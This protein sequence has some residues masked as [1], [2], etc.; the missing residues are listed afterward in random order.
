VIAIYEKYKIYIIGGVICFALGFGVQFLS[1]QGQLQSLRVRADQVNANYNR[2]RN[3]LE[4]SQK[5][6]ADL[7]K[8]IGAAGETV[9]G[10]TNTASNIEKSNREIRESVNMAIREIES[11]GDGFKDARRILETVQNRGGGED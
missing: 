9:A 6:L 4:S 3:E 2:V 11:S 7:Q 5:Q 1:S 8:A 10:V